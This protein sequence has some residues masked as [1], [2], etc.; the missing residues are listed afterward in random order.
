MNELEKFKDITRNHWFIENQQHWVLDVAF[1]EDDNKAFIANQR[2]NL[3]LFRRV[4]LNLIRTNG[5]A[6]LSIKRS[7][8]KASL[9]P[10]YRENLLWT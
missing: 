1:R 7:R 9:N 10:D 4:A 5:N 6:K 3:A 2:S 8:I